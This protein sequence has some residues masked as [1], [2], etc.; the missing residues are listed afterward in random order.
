MSIFFKSSDKNNNLNNNYYPVNSGLGML[1]LSENNSEDFLY[2]TKIADWSFLERIN[3]AET[4]KEFFSLNYLNNKLLGIS[5]KLEQPK[6]IYVVCN[7]CSLRFEKNLVLNFLKKSLGDSENDE[8]FSCKNLT[9]L[10]REIIETAMQKM[11]SK[12]SDEIAEITQREICRGHINLI[13]QFDGG[14]AIVTLPEN[15]I[16]F[17]PVKIEKIFPVSHEKFKK[18]IL[19]VNLIFGSSLIPV[20]ELKT[21]EAGDYFLFENSNITDAIISGTDKISKI[22]ESYLNIKLNLGNKIKKVNFSSIIN[23]EINTNK[24][25]SKKMNSFSQDAL[26]KFK[27]NV[28]A[29]FRNIKLR[30]EKILA[31]KEGN[32]LELDEIVNSE[33]YLVSQG[34]TIA[35]GDLVVINN[36]F[37]MVIKEILL[38]QPDSDAEM[39]DDRNSVVEIKEP[40]RAN[41]NQV[42]KSTKEEESFDEQGSSE[43][44]EDSFSL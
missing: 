41:N 14:K 26:G 27:I 35:K 42:K 3:I 33:L 10:E 29:E 34:K 4:C 44:E 16:K 15:I 18:I 37:G 39:L 1:D 6:G 2:K 8:N 22:T 11:I 28:N 24:N 32:L 12:I 43:S 17:C 5:Q 9:D 30:L 19:F 20:Q 31:L 36:K 40:Q 23:S 21:L 25:I 7:N 38:D 13:W